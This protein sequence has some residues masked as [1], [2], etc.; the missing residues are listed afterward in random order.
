MPKRPPKRPLDDIPK[1]QQPT[2]NQMIADG[3][4]VRIARA[5]DEAEV[6]KIEAVVD[7]A[8]DEKHGSEFFMHFGQ[9]EQDQKM[10]G[11]DQKVQEQDQK[12]QEQDQKVQDDAIDDA[13]DDVIDVDAIDDVIDVD[14]IDDVIDVD[15]CTHLNL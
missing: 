2:T 9:P 11:Q 14:A 5:R 10:Q 3:H 8:S 13:I 12:M 6:K 7:S 15:A 4:Y 1:G